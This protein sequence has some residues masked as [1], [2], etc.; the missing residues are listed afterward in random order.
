MLRDQL[1][2]ALLELPHVATQELECR[3]SRRMGSRHV[4]VAEV[5]GEL[6]REQDEGACSSF[7]LPDKQIQF[8]LWFGFRLLLSERAE[9]NYAQQFRC[10]LHIC[11]VALL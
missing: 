11:A 5:G 2:L 3:Q 7:D 9:R 4:S 1:Q 6:A 8:L 10:E